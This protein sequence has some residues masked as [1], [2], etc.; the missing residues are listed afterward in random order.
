MFGGVGLGA[1]TK[2]P[3]GFAGGEGAVRPLNVLRF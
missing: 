3:L 2:L 1:R